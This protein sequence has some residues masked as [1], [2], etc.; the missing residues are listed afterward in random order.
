M[1]NTHIYTCVSQ[2]LVTWR[3]RESE[4]SSP[5]YL[6]PKHIMRRT[7]VVHSTMLA[8]RL[9]FIRVR[10]GLFSTWMVT[11]W[12]RFDIYHFLLHSLAGSTRSLQE[13]V[14]V[15]SR[16]YI[17]IDNRLTINLCQCEFFEG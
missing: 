6:C 2:T 11:I 15:D 16:V 17:Y 14:M 5:W 7:L 8:A 9:S 12:Y 1:Y 13:Q 10:Q 3:Q 4:L